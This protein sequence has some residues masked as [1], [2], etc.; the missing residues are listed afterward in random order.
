MDELVYVKFNGAMLDAFVQLNPTV[1]RSYIMMENGRKVLYAKLQKALYGT[2]RATLLF[3]RDLADTLEQEDFVLNPYDHCVMNKMIDGKQCTVLF[4]VDDLKISHD[5]GT[6]VTNVI[7][8][9]KKRY[10]KFKK[11]MSITRG[12]THEYLGMVL[13]FT[14]PGKIR[15]DMTKF[16]DK[17][18]EGMPEEMVGEATTAA[19]SYLFSINDK[20]EN[21]SE[22]LSAVFHRLTAQGLFLCARARPDIETAIAFLTTRVR[23]PDKDDWKKLTRI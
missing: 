8:I 16:V 1:Y 9:L 6:V 7:A 5:S 19:A 23:G 12:K 15:I 2:V 4:H 21:L 18:I 3:W 22:E 13:D 20:C 14:I 17:M 10:D 11:A